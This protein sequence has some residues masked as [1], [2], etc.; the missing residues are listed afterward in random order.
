MKIGAIIYTRLGSERL[1]NKGLIYFGKKKLVELVIERVKKISNLENIILA[2]S[3]SKLDKKLQATA[4]N[5]KI[6]FF[7]GSENDV[8]ERTFK[9]LKKFKMKY[10]LR[11]CGDRIF[12]DNHFIDK[13]LIRL[14]KNKTPYD[15]ISNNFNSNVDPGLTVEILSFECI[16]KLYLNKKL[17]LYNKEHITSFIYQNCEMFNI[18]QLKSPN[19]HYQKYKY[20]IDNK[21]DVFFAKKILSKIQK[22]DLYEFKNIYKIYKKLKK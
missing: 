15:L 17:N 2:T 21:K 12:F 11:V 18:K 16:K 19:Y 20:T 8:I 10:F 5:Y 9:C 4:K 6:P 13:T 14:K 3:N 1:K 22:D 7:Q